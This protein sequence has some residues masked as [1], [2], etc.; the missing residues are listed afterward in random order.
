MGSIFKNT[1]ATATSKSV[2]CTNLYMFPKKDNILEHHLDKVNHLKPELL[3]STYDSST[4]KSIQSSM[5]ESANEISD[6]IKIIT[7]S[8]DDLSNFELINSEYLK[9]IISFHRF[10]KQRGMNE[11][12]PSFDDFF[13]S[14]K[15]GCINVSNHLINYPSIRIVDFSGNAEIL[16]R[17]ENEH[18]NRIRN[19]LANHVVICKKEKEEVYM[20]TLTSKKTGNTHTLYVHMDTDTGTNTIQH[21]HNPVVSNDKQL[22]QLLNNNM[23]QNKTETHCTI[24]P[25]YESY[26]NLVSSSRLA[27]H[28]RYSES[29]IENMQSL[30]SS[31]FKH[32]E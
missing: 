23:I 10:I 16:T 14:Y 32:N 21:I 28:L 19:I 6:R 12:A 30:L 11:L 26:T 17:L 24:Q 22:M 27:E 20:Y 9:N 31:L 4:Y 15:Q 29:N 7:R 1:L 8:I 2:S 25:H 18:G 3:R 13:S 5:I